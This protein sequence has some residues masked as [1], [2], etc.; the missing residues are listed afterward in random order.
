[1]ETLIADGESGLASAEVAQ[2]LDRVHIELKT[3]APG[4]HAQMVERH[5]ELL[6]RILLRIED[7]LEEEGIKVPLSVVVAEG[8]LAKN[9]LT[10][11]AGHTPYRALYG[12]DPP[13]LA[14]FE[15][16][17]ETQLDDTSGGVAGSSRHNHRVREVAIAALS[18]IHI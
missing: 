9:T 5:H 17:S 7:Q 8:A 2:Y 11:V 1:M 12:R 13:G 15:P 4:E 10:R 18:L 14:E 3:K 16:V 6:R